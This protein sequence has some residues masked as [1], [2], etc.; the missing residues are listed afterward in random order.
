MAA[1]SH[2]V[3]T[4]GLLFV[5]INMTPS[6]IW[7]LRFFHAVE[8]IPKRSHYCE[9]WLCR[10]RGTP[11]SLVLLELPWRWAGWGVSGVFS[12]DWGSRVAIPIH[13]ALQIDPIRGFPCVWDERQCESHLNLF[14]IPLH[15]VTHVLIGGLVKAGQFDLEHTGCIQIWGQQDG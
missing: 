4:C 5:Q 7:K 3:N 9:K 6:G 2:G 12:S 13:L 1:W 10:D 11:E 14:S 15:T 8:R